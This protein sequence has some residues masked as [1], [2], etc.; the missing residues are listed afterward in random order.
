M[1]FKWKNVCS[2]LE[3][4][5]SMWGTPTI[6]CQ[7]LPKVREGAGRPRKVMQMG[8][9]WEQSTGTEHMRKSH[10]WDVHG[11]KIH[12]KVTDEMWTEQNM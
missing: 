8:C 12:E 11:N 5:S 3:T 6:H 1:V 4:M 2:L 7:R 10:G 9:T